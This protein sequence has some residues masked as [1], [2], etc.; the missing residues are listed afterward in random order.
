[1]LD[2]QAEDTINSPKHDNSLIKFLVENSDG[3][4]EDKI[5]RVLDLTKDEVA[6]ILTKAL[7]KMRE[8]MVKGDEE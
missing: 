4:A 7:A 1:V 5:A 3:V 8:K 2:E 6:T